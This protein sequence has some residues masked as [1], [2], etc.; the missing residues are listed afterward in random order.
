MCTMIGEKI[1][2]HA[3]AKG[4]AEWFTADH[5]YVAYDHPTHANLDHALGIDFVRETPD[6][7]DSRMQRIAVELDLHNARAIRDALTRA[8]DQA[9]L[10]D[11]P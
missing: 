1:A 4:G 6:G 5:A 3:S 11:S 7:G 8:I 10:H 2:L 9:A